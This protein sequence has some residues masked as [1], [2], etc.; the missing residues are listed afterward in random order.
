MFLRANTAWQE[1][2]EVDPEKEHDQ[3]SFLVEYKKKFISGSHIAPDSLS[4]TDAWI[5]ESA[6]RILQCSSLYYHNISQ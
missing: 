2:I 1:N 4:L 6:D 5:L 3:R